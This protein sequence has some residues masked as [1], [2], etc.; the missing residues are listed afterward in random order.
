MA[1]RFEHGEFQRAQL[2]GVALLIGVGVDEVAVAHVAGIVAVRRVDVDRD[3]GQ[4]AVQ[5]L[6]GACVV[7]MRVRQQD[8][9]DFPACLLHA[10]QDLLR[11]RAGVD[12]GAKAALPVGD[13]IAVRAERPERKRENVHKK[14]LFKACRRLW[15]RR[16]GDHTEPRR[17]KRAAALFYTKTRLK[18]SMLSGLNC[19]RMRYLPCWATAQLRHLPFLAQFILRNLLKI[20]NR[21]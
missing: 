12:H 14:L 11:G 10:Q 5:R 21:F 1:G 4:R 16:T 17:R 2:H 8:Q 19:A 3:G 20:S 7:K 13:E 9:A 15:R 6:Q 18:S